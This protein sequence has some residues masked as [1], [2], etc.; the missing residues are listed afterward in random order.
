MLEINKWFFVQL[1]NFLLLL[2]VL[3]IIL[4]KPILRLFQ[5]RKDS[6]TGFLDKARELDREKDEVLANIEAK[7]KE[8]RGRARE[9]FEGLSRE[10][11]EMQ[12]KAIESSQG[13]AAEMN[14][15]A[16][17]EIGTAAEKARS[18]LK[19][20]IE[21]FSNQIVRKLVGTE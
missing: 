12:K 18:T 1:A 7:L 11:L 2:L 9:D 10:A 13:E 14:R 3:N 21:N 8:A 6:T 16:K 5:E 17:A 19:A 15:K 4:F 20:N